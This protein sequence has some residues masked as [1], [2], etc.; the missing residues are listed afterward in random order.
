MPRR[1]Q[2]LLERRVAADRGLEGL[3]LLEAHRRLDARALAPTRSRRPPRGRR[4]TPGHTAPSGGAGG[5]P[6]RAGGDRG[7]RAAASAVVID[8]NRTPSSS[9]R[10]PHDAR[11]LRDPVRRAGR[12]GGI[13]RC[14]RRSWSEWISEL[15]RCQVSALGIAWG[16]GEA[17]GV[18]SARDNEGRE[19][20]LEATVRV[21]AEHGLRG[22]PTGAWPRRAQ[23]IDALV[24]YHFGSW[25]AL[26]LEAA[27]RP[28]ADAGGHLLRDAAAPRRPTSPRAPGPRPARGAR[29]C[30]Q[31][32]LALEARR[33]RIS[34]RRSG[35]ATSTLRDHPRRAARARHRP[36]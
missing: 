33:G 10:R 29:P 26:I 24:S 6:W 9:V 16:H 4:R 22:S 20:L 30:L 19:A 3:D 18:R 25:D 14:T 17:R 36:R 1:S 32:E 34:A 28:D 12:E 13:V 21:V 11:G 27:A 2:R 31:F 23:T 5:P 35:P 7:R 15:T 8:T